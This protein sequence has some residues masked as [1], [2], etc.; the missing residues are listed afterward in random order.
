MADPGRLDELERKFEENPKRYFAPLAN[1]YRKAG[2]PEQAIELCRTYLPQQPAHMS[3][4][5]V[6][7]QSLRDAGHVAEADAVFRQALTLDPENIIALRNL[8]DVARDAGDKAGAMHWYGKML[9]LDPRNEE[10]AAYIAT[11]SGQDA[12]APHER[13]PAVER[14][15]PPSMRPEP[16]PDESAVR[17]AD[18]MSQPDAEVAPFLQRSGYEGTPAAEGVTGAAQ[19]QDEAVADTLTQPPAARD[20]ASPASQSPFVTATMAELYVQQGL[21]GE[22]LTIYRQLS[23]RSDDPAAT[24][25]ITDRLAQLEAEEAEEAEEAAATAGIPAGRTESVRSF[26]ARIGAARS[27]ERA[28]SAGDTQSPLSAL[29]DSSNQDASDL[30]AAQ[31]LA[32]AFG[33]T[34]SRS[35]QS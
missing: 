8:G 30:A 35:Y 11:L 22:A 23:V 33:R 19:S 27:E 18:L 29:F 25:R 13:A 20:P 14:P 15:A 12:H 10:I 16:E 1:E 31:R 32:G 21:R 5:I 6:Y 17:L 9:E 28:P 24:R 3:G 7:A 4:Y 26:F 34:A 2:R